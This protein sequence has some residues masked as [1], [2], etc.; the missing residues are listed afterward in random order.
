MLFLRLKAN[1]SCNL[2]RPGRSVISVGDNPKE[3]IGG[4]GLTTER[5][6]G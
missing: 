2:I 5:R 6:S 1:G 4:D 3:D